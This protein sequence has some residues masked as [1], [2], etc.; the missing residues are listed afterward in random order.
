MAGFFE[1]TEIFS[2]DVI[3]D[4]SQ[5]EKSNIMNEE[6]IKTKEKIQESV[7]KVLENAGKNVS[8]FQEAESEIEK[9]NWAQMG[10]FSEYGSFESGVFSFER[11]NDDD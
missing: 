3:S 7:E 6:S 10:L 1:I 5:S 2:G 9:K 8:E 11:R 4:S